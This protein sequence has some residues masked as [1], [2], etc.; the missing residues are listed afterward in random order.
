MAPAEACRDVEALKMRRLQV[1][2]WLRQ[3]RDGALSRPAAAGR[4][5]VGDRTEPLT[6]ASGPGG[7]PLVEFRGLSKNFGGTRAVDDVSLTVERG[8]ILALLGEN[9][10]GK[11]T[12]IKLIAGVHQPD[13]GLILL[14]GRRIDHRHDRRRLAF[15]HQDHGLVDAMTVI[16]NIALVGGYDRRLGLI[17]WRETQAAATRALEQVG[18][19]VDL[20]T[21]VSEL[22]RT[23]RSLVAIARALAMDPELLVLDEPTA[24]L[25]AADV[26]RLFAA[27]RRLRARG[28]GMIYVTH[29]IDEVFRIADRVAVMRDGHLVTVRDVPS[30]SVGELVQAIVGRPLI[31]VFGR[32]PRPRRNPLLELREVHLGHLKPVSFSVTAGELIGLAGLRGAGHQLLGRAL[33]GVSRGLGGEITIR[34]RPARLGSPREAIAAGVTFIT[35]NRQEESLAPNLSVRE[36]LFLNPSTRGRHP[37]SFLL[38]RS[39]RREALDLIQRFHVRPPDSERVIATLSGGNQQKCVLARGLATSNPVFV[40]EDPTQGVDVGAKAEIYALMKDALA[41]ECCI[42]ILSSDFEEIAHVCNRALVFNRGRLV[43][44]LSRDEIELSRLIELASAA[45]P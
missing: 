17:D 26:E 4:H 2:E 41:S 44:E 12:L 3:R 34:G 33:A 42:L 9:G 11:S 35:S 45:V 40:V 23:E 15:I 5:S 1:T 27:L 24:S 43:A 29:R 6:A 32:A 16:E 20:T 13:R 18:L 31:D 30:T 22:S 37:F 7:V 25:P 21:A 28:V 19:A 14:D 10:A 38:H 36:N 8:H 39:E